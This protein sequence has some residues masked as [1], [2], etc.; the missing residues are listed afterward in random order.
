MVSAARAIQD[1]NGVTQ[2]EEQFQYDQIS[3]D[4]D[5]ICVKGA[6]LKEQFPSGNDY[7]PKVVRESNTTDAISVKPIEI[8]PP[9]PKRKPVHPYPRK[10]VAPLT[11]GTADEQPRR[12]TSP[13]LSVSE[14]EN[15]SPTSVFS[16]IGSEILG[17][18]GSNTPNDSPSPVSSAA[19]ANN[20]SFLLSEPN[21]SPEES[22]SPLVVQLPSIS[23]PDVQ[24][25]VILTD[26]LHQPRE[27]ASHR[28]LIHYHGIQ[29][30][31][32]FHRRIQRVHGILK[33][34]EHLQLSTTCNFQIRTQIQQN[35]VLVILCHCGLS[36]E[37]YNFLAFHCITQFQQRQIHHPLVG[38]P[39][40]EKFKRK[41]L[42]LVQT[43]DHTY[44]GS[45]YVA[46]LCEFLYFWNCE[47]PVI[48]LVMLVSGWIVIRGSV[49]SIT[50]PVGSDCKGDY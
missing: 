13:N 42:G 2:N 38:K 46:F 35:L 39:K 12:S 11:T 1:Q 26:H 18:T 5:P 48:S 30:Q 21:S 3:M 40:R 7:S 9:R 29:P 16:A 27:L 50:C 47:F 8:P 4:V 49:G 31:Q 20:G 23:A 36:M 41:D 28:F 25:P 43:P 24:V 14:H 6:Q 32:N 15:Q 37:A 44:S 33:R 10:L 22:G 45:R 19:V 34:V 17:T